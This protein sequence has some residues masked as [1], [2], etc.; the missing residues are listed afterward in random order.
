ML[1]VPLLAAMLA[2]S[3]AQVDS[4]IAYRSDQFPYSKSAYQTGQVDAE[5]D[6]HA[7]RLVIEDFGFP[8]KGQAEYAEILQR[9][10]RVELRRVAS[11]IVDLKAY[12]HA[13]GYN[14]VSKQE[15]KRRFGDNILEKAQEEAAKRYDEQQS[16]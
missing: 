1:F 10:Y 5:A 9:R 11:D 8:R 3:H 6:L 12:G 4:D 16:K 2:G 13:F 15:I 14:D 7:D